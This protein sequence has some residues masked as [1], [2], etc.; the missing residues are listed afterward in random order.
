MIRGIKC[1]LRFIP[2]TFIIKTYKLIPFSHHAPN[3]KTNE[4]SN[5][6]R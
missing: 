1:T 5:P 6:K 2:L 4:R 3:R